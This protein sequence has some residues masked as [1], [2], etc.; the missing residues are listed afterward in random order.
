MGDR[1]T[2]SKFSKKKKKVEG[3]TGEPKLLWTSTNE[4]YI[5]LHRKY[6]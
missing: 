5:R 6:R 4:D 3:N 2:V 1:H